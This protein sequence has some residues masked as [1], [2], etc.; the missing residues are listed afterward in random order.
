MPFVVQVA[1]SV[2]ADPA[3]SNDPT[4]LVSSSID[5][6][7]RGTY[8]AAWTG[9]QPI[10]GTDITPFVPQLGAVTKVR[11]FA[12]RAVDQQSL[13]VKITWAGGTD[14]TVPVS[15]QWLIANQN[16]GDV[17]SAIKIV[18]SGRIEYLIGG[19]R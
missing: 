8:D 17:I 16:D 5:L 4:S 9:N 7:F 2:Q 18:G 3:T 14:Q 10:N 1:G 15:G 19:D 11:A 6:A 13:V 12:I